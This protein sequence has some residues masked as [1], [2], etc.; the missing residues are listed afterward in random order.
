METLDQITFFPMQD[1]TVISNTI[2][3]RSSCAYHEDSE[4]D[5]IE[6]SVPRPD[7][8][9]K[10]PLYDAIRRCRS[11]HYHHDEEALREQVVNVQYLDT[12][13][14]PVWSN[15]ISSDQIQTYEAHPSGGALSARHEFF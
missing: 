10:L 14:H 1:Y 13:R 4:D 12:H 6:P 2:G 15:K 8:E 11:F 7:D 3:Q 5:E 9:A